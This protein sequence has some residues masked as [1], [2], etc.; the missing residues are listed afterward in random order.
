MTTPTAEA[1]A[2]EA[3]ATPIQLPYPAAPD[4]Q[5]T[6]SVGA[7]H[8]RM[9][10]GAGGEWLTGTYSDPSGSLPCQVL[11]EGSHARVTQD[12]RMPPQW[13]RLSRP[14][15]FDLALGKSQPFALVIEGGACDAEIDLGGVP[16]SRLTGK[17][18][19]GKCVFNFS[20]PNPQPMTL[21]DIAA[22]AASMEVRNL[23]NANA[24]EIL[25]Q[26]GAAAY[27]FD[28]GG[29]LQ[30]DTH[31]RVT[32]GLSSLHLDIPSSTAA[33]VACES[34][35]GSVEVGDGFTRRDGVFWTAAA[36]AGERPLL[37]ITASI[38]LGM[39]QVRLV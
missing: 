18:G 35:L 16:L 9:R 33:I 39:V 30:R 7:C 6:V 36:L 32:A 2:A 5:L 29:V 11:G 12:L 34:F 31:V 10:P 8:L 26:G 4:K 3:I 38:T 14:P 23:A 27:A 15:T 19:A 21:F 37:R 28:F 22:G 20:A 1:I 25:L 17:L 24:A 13:G